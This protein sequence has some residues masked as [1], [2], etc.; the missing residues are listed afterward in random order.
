MVPWATLALVALNAALFWHPIRSPEGACLSVRTVWDRGQWQRILLAPFH[1]LSLCH[2][3][4]NMATLFWLGKGME[5][6]VG[7]LR[8]GG[9]LLSL[10][11]LGGVLHLMLNMLLAT[12]TGHSWYREHCAVGFSGS[13]LRGVV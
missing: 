5:E 3:L 10:A 6:Q 12:A 11:L 9:V 7:S 1:H 13:F 8:T 2:L 4:L